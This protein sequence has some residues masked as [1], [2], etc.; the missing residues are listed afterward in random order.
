MRVRVNK[1]TAHP[2][3]CRPD[4]SRFFDW[5]KWDFIGRTKRT[6][7]MGSPSLHP[8]PTPT[9]HLRLSLPGSLLTI[10]LSLTEKPRAR[11]RILQSLNLHI[12][13][14]KKN[15]LFKQKIRT[16]PID[17]SIRLLSHHRNPFVR[18]IK[19]LSSVFN[20]FPAIKCLSYELSEWILCCKSFI[21][22]N[23]RRS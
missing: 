18:L 16:F 11:Y 21:F 22:W 12:E 5:E 13:V 6:I 10:W 7:W 4:F 1:T 19:V 3:M 17:Y 23:P 9:L 14:T 2:T 15:I 8:T 20:F